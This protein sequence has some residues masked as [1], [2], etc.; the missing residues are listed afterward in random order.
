MQSNEGISEN[1]L[2]PAGTNVPL[3]AAV[4]AIFRFSLSSLRGRIGQAI[5]VTL[6]LLLIVGAAQA[7]GA[8]GDDD[9]HYLSD[10]LG[11]KI[12]PVVYEILLEFPK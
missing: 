10:A 7:I 4:F 1:K 5:P 2:S 6:A 11:P 8:L 12:K 9:G 3:S